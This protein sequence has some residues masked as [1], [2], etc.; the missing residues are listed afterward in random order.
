M[1]DA[2]SSIQI[3]ESEDL[4]LFKPDSFYSREA[5]RRNCGGL[6]RHG[7]GGGGRHQ[8][9][10]DQP[11]RRCYPPDLPLVSVRPRRR[12]KEI[13][14]SEKF[15][16]AGTLGTKGV[17]SFKDASAPGG[18]RAVRNH[19]T[20]DGADQY[21]LTAIKAINALSPAQIL[22]AHNGVMAA[23]VILMQQNFNLE[24]G[25]EQS[26]KE[27]SFIGYGTASAAPPPVLL[28]PAPGPSVESA[29]VIELRKKLA[30]SEESNRQLRQNTQTAKKRG[31]DDEDKVC[32]DFQSGTCRRGRKCKYTHRCLICDSTEHGADACPQKTAATKRE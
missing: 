30:S 8:A 25:M 28:P 20:P 24:S 2:P 4:P 27:K 6:H 13:T 19:I 26:L 11:G 29:E 10:R 31:P 17:V 12:L 22:T 16:D 18:Y 23:S 5:L 14:P 32:T 3:H 7:Q 1:R 9:R 21:V 15:P